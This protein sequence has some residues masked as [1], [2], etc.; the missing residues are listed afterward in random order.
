[1][2]NAAME[3]R[4]SY[5]LTRT[6]I[7]LPKVVSISLHAAMSMHDKAAALAIIQVTANMLHDM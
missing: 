4:V 7:R 3:G 2:E 5:L 1:M 6:K